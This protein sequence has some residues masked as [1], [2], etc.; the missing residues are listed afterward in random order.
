MRVA[1]IFVLFLLVS[2]GLGLLL[3][4][5]VWGENDRSPMDRRQAERVA[6]R[7]TD[8]SGDARES[9]SDVHESTGDGESDTQWES[10]WK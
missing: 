10:G 9:A 5:L 8:E 7:D 1:G 3:A 6:R 4:M 2:V